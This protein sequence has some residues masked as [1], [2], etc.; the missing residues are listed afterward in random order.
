MQRQKLLKAINELSEFRTAT[1]SLFKSQSGL[2]TAIIEFYGALPKKQDPT[3]ED[4]KTLEAFNSVIEALKVSVTSSQDYNKS[5]DKEYIPAMKVLFELAK[6][7][8]NEE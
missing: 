2:I 6:V 7:G 3:D 1:Q 5:M 8:K 4:V